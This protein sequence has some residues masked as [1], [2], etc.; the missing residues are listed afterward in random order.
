MSLTLGLNTALSGLLG[1]Q[2]SLNV[3]S[4]N[5]SNVNT[6]GYDRE[7]VNQQSITLAGHGAG[8]T[9]LPPQRQVDLGLIKQLNNQT[10]VVGQLNAEQQYYP[11]IEDMFGTVGDQ[12]SISATLTTLTTSM[13]SLSAQAN[14][15]A[16]QS[17]AVNSA[18]N[19]TN[20]LNQMTDTLQNLRLQADSQL[21]QDVGQV[22]TDLNNVWSLNQKIVRAKAIKTDT[23]SLEDQR[24]NTIK[25]L[26]K[27]IGIQYYQNGDGSTSIYTNTGKVLLANQPNL[28]SHSAA[29]IT[30]SWMSAAGGQFSGITLQNDQSSDI[31]S[32]L[33]TSGSGEISALLTVRDQTIPNLQAQ[34][35]ELAYQLKNTVNEIN[36][37]GTSQPNITNTYNGSRTFGTQGQL[38]QTSGD[39]LGTMNFFAGG[40]V[41][42]ISAG[43]GGAGGTGF[44]TLAYSYSSTDGQM[45][46]TG[47]GANPQSLSTLAKGTTFTISGSA[48]VN[49]VANANDGTYTVTDYDAGTNT[50][51]VRK[52]NPVQTFSLANNADVV[53]AIFD[54]N[55]TQLA[56]STVSQI[57]GTDYSGGPG[58]DA[59][60]VNMPN[61]GPWSID[62]FS[63]HMTSWLQAQ[64]YAGASAGLDSSG[65][66]NITL[67]SSTQ[68]SLAFRDQ[69]S[70]TNGGTATDATVNF[71]ADGGTPMTGVPTEKAQQSTGFSNFMGLNDLLVTKQQDFVWDS[72]IQQNGFATAVNRSFRIN[73]GSGQVGNTVNVAAGSS[74]QQIADA[75]NA[76]TQTVDSALIPAGTGGTTV[77]S[78]SLSTQGTIT[79]SDAHGTVASATL[80]VNLAG[81][82]L[83]DIAKALNSPSVVAK[84]EQD[85]SQYRLSL[86][87]T[88]GVPLTATISGGTTGPNTSLATQ[89]ALTSTNRVRAVV[90][91]EGP[92]QRLRLVQAASEQISVA[93]DNYGGTT[94]LDDLGMRAASS[95]VASAITVR[96]DVKSNPGAISR[97]AV[98]WN[99][100]NGEYY[101]STGD[102]TTAMQMAQT[103][104]NPIA[105]DSAGAL[106]RGNYSLAGH[107][108]ATISLV[109]T[110]S[111]NSQQQQQYQQT[112]ADSLNKQYTSFSGVNIDEEVTN[113]I[114]YQQA[115]S[116]SARVISVLQ[117]MLQTL[118]DMIH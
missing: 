89:L 79:I 102:N 46:I 99:A 42:A 32:D 78:F 116:A 27:Y 20:Q 77:P 41:A 82:S 105:M 86:Y 6:P 75:I 50:L 11:Q 108:A 91:P 30:G 18:L 65:H 81:Y 117:S 80:P 51:E 103:L 54:P 73:D 22:N 36:N 98:Q 95:D 48:T 118:N 47:T 35:D 97:G 37:R 72:D 23:S 114:S 76:Q 38:A 94:I 33:A 26:S 31:S 53:V 8:M 83:N 106:N 39:A 49:G 111:A 85:G 28:L 112:L 110:D 25:D 92:G 56:H 29:T 1:S 10:N 115:Y 61:G 88:S 34:V 21:S 3:I 15:S 2:Q 55:G 71:Y 5:I 107:A 24:D 67:G 84:V 59:Q 66:M 43:N 60:L 13:Q 101:L 9:M 113:M 104:A 17:T 40:T 4:Q 19:T 63:K 93:G 58:G 74:L 96:S 14:Q 52:G 64:G 100:D 90:T 7:V 109:A 87:S 12:T 69:I 62:S 44:G 68:A 57:M 16:A 70:A 45:T